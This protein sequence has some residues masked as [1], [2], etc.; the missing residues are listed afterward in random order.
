MWFSSTGVNFQSQSGHQKLIRPTDQLID[1]FDTETKRR[2]LD[3]IYVTGN[4]FDNQWR[5]FRQQDISILILTLYSNICVD[6]HLHCTSELFI[7]DQ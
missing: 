4:H 2:H 1:P 3:K 6:W 5:K 7:W